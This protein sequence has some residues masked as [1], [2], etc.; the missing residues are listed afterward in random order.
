MRVGHARRN[1][2]E[3][4]TF[5]FRRP[6]NVGLSRYKSRIYEL[7]ADTYRWVEPR[8]AEQYHLQGSAAQSAVKISIR[9]REVQSK[10][11]PHLVGPYPFTGQVQLVFD[12]AGRLPCFPELRSSRIEDA[13]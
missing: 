12:K 5:A 10:F 2:D 6:R 7:D 8:P 11:N 1:G 3:D 9:G 4:P 13:G